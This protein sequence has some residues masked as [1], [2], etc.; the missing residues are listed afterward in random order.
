[1]EIERKYL[2]THC[3]FDLSDFPLQTIRQGYISKNPVI[4]IRQSNSEYILTVKGKGLIEREEYELHLDEEQFLSLIPKVEGNFIEKTRYKI[5]YG[6][7]I[8]ELD[9]FHG[10]LE[11]LCFAEVE[12]ENHEAMINFTPPEWFDLDVSENPSYQNSHL[13][14]LSPEE[15]LL[16]TKGNTD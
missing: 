12:F 13:S 2:V 7:F 3:P 6:D 14:K 16:I 8:I 11:G 15:A 1:M 5:P 4:R 9:I 10:Y